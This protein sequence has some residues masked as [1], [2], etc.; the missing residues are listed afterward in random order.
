MHKSYFNSTSFSTTA[1]EKEINP[2][3]KAI[4]D[5]N[6][7]EF[8]I[9]EDKESDNNSNT[10]IPE[11]NDNINQEKINK[12]NISYVGKYKTIKQIENNIEHIK[13]INRI[14]KN[15]IKKKV[16]LSKEI[17]NNKEDIFQIY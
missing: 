15:N 17:N 13:A 10:D 9:E 14:I 4:N 7:S 3:Q 16:N 1:G 8:R 6:I 11:E 12:I 2:I 5:I